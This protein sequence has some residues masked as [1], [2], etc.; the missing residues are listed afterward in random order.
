M[1]KDKKFAAAVGIGLTFGIVLGALT[2][3]VGLWMSIGLALGVGAGTAL[4]KKKE[5]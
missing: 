3:N 5:E 4:S 2:E 1:K